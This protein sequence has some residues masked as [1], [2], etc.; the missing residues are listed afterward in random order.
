MKRWILSPPD[1]VKAEEISRHFQLSPLIS[2]ILVNRNITSPEDLT[3]FLQP[4]LAHL[5]DPEKMKD[6]QK[7]TKKMK[8]TGAFH[9]F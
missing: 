3:H 7:A 4:S 8:L 6:M 1:P 5:P 9:L 2:Q